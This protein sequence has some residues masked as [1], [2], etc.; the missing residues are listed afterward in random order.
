MRKTTAIFIALA[1]CF[2]T[3][4]S[5]Y[6]LPHEDYFYNNTYNHD[7]VDLVYD[8][9]IIDEVY[10]AFENSKPTLTVSGNKLTWSNVKGATSYKVYRRGILGITVVFTTT[11]TSFKDVFRI[12]GVKYHY[13]VQAKKVVKGKSV[14]S[15][16]SNTK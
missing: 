3:I 4:M 14:L 11:D 5:C 7:N 9:S 6:A 10:T 1:L 12:P 13:Q 8:S 15:K 16:K 2:G